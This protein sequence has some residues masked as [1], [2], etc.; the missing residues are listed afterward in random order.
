M[1]GAMC[2]NVVDSSQEVGCP[3]RHPAITSWNKSFH[4]G[5]KAWQ[6]L[7]VLRLRRLLRLFR[8]A[9]SCAVLA[10]HLHRLARWCRWWAQQLKQPRYATAMF[11]SN[12]PESLSPLVS[13]ARTS[14][15]RQTRRQQASKQASKQARR[16]A[17]SKQAGRQQ[18]SSK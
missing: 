18:A 9:Q 12:Q 4:C 1:V 17:A 11:H 5:R 8:L 6:V 3:I 15:Q 16:Q 14:R 13:L 7:S 10:C 2:I